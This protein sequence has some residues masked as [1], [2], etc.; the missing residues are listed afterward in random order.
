MNIIAAVQDGGGIG[1]QNQL[2]FTIP[3]DMAHF[4]AT[5]MGKVV[6]MGRKTLDS[7]PGGKPLPGRTNVVL[8]QSVA[9]IPEVIVVRSIPHLLEIL[10]PYPPQDVFVIGGGEVYAQLLPYC[11]RAYITEV[12]ATP[13]KPADSFFPALSSTWQMVSQSLQADYEEMRYRFCVYEKV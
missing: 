6:V 13:P 7:L 9:A 3:Q 1:Y 11:N 5:T 4:K 12:T 8:T 2:L 10:A